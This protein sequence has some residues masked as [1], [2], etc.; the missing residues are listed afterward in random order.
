LTEEAKGDW[1]LGA[2]YK[3]D[4]DGIY[5]GTKVEPGSRD[6]AEL[7]PRA[8]TGTSSEGEAIKCDC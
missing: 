6:K 2:L 5:I 7:D 4:A 3:K 1:G 8:K